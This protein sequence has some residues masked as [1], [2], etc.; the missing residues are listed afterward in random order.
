MPLIQIDVQPLSDEHRTELRVR[1]LAH[2]IDVP[3][4]CGQSEEAVDAG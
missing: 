4:H 1:A 2:D 3:C